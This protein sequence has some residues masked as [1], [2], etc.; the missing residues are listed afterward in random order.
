MSH[1][2]FSSIPEGEYGYF[3][4]KNEDARN[5]LKH[6]GIE[7]AFHADFEY[8]IDFDIGYSFLD[9]KWL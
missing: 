5:H 3:L 9:E 8:S 2:N 1:I 4:E 7:S 6:M